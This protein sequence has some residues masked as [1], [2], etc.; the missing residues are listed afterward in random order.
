MNS[1]CMITYMINSVA[2]VTV[3]EGC[4]GHVVVLLCEGE[5]FVNLFSQRGSN[6]V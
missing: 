4:G 5:M 2:Q 3:W 1:T 6:T